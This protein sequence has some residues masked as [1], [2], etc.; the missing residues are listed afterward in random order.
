MVCQSACGPYGAGTINQNELVSTRD[1]KRPPGI[2]FWAIV[3]FLLLDV[4]AIIW[5]KTHM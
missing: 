1:Y 3:T 4:A 5:V 2:V